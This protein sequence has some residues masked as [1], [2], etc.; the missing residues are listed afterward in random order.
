MRGFRNYLENGNIGKLL[1]KRDVSSK[2]TPVGNDETTPY[3]NPDVV[4]DDISAFDAMN[5][6]QQDRWLKSLTMPQWVS[7]YWRRERMK[8]KAKT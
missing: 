4:Y 3:S 6:Q 7:F 8:K 2:R 5:P 1:P